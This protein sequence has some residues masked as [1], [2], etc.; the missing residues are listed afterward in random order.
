MQ[1]GD[2]GLR[3]LVPARPPNKAQDVLGSG[4]VHLAA[5]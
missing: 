1:V 5:V 4:E 3:G 2:G